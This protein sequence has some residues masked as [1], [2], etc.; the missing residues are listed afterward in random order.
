[1]RRR[2]GP[3]GRRRGGRPAVLNVPDWAM[4]GA[5]AMGSEPPA[6]RGPD[7]PGHLEHRPVVLAQGDSGEARR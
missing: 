7:R 4:K 2:Q 5:G 3:Q 1:V 6:P